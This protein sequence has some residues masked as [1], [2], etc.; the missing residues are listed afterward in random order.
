MKKFCFSALIGAVMLV[1]LLL[2][3]ADPAQT[4]MVNQL[5]RQM[6]QQEMIPEDAPAPVT[7]TGIASNNNELGAAYN[8]DTVQPL[9]VWDV[10]EAR[11]SDKSVPVIGRIEIPRVG[12]NLSILKGV[13]KEA[14]A[15]GAG[16]MKPDQTMGKGNY[17]L[18]SH[19]I[20]GKD[21]L[22][23]PLYD[24]RVGDT[25]YVSNTGYRYEY[26]T[27]E[28]RVIEATEVSIIEDI[29]DSVLLTLITCAKKG[30]KRLA[31][32]AELVSYSAKKKI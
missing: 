15:A 28:I 21:I 3:L 17:S 19:Y 5:S 2:V 4:I 30:E 23:G 8:F 25:I 7:V 27:T 6:N 11:T 12:L 13:G 10:W 20:E 31:V 18:A 14:L 26:V 1:G 9:T 32:Q 24:M 16:T 22:F 29:P